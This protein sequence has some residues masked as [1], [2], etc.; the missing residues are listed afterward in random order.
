M[1]SCSVP[2]PSVSALPPPEGRTASLCF[3]S[4][5]CRFVRGGAASGAAWVRPGYGPSLGPPSPSRLPRVLAIQLVAVAGSRVCPN[6]SAQRWRLRRPLTRPPRRGRFAGEGARGPGAMGVL[7]AEGVLVL[8]QAC[9]GCVSQ[10]RGFDA[11]T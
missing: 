3:P 11:S 4:L 6:G 7:G 2:E 9:I 8:Y 10:Q 1:E 5:T